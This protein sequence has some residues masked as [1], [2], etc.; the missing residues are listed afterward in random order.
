[1]NIFIISVQHYKLIHKMI[2]IKRLI[3]NNNYK[4][5][6][7]NDSNEMKSFFIENKIPFIYEYKEYRF[8]SINPTITDVINF[9]RLCNL[10]QYEKSII[11]TLKLIDRL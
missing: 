9:K 5:I 11:K 8:N 6:V 3:N 4:I 1:M 7:V 2:S 10:T